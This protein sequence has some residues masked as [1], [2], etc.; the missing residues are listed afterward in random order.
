MSL[1]FNLT[2]RLPVNFNLCLILT[3]VHAI[4]WPGSQHALAVSLKSVP[5]TL[6]DDAHATMDK[7][8][9]KAIKRPPPEDCYLLTVIVIY[10]DGLLDPKYINTKNAMVLLEDNQQFVEMLEVAWGRR[11]FR[12]IR[13][14]GAVSVQFGRN[15]S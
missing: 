15:P 12:D 8:V 5:N 4:A 9:L 7:A 2:T 10:S 1:V 6:S 14:L 13:N 11:Q 3:D